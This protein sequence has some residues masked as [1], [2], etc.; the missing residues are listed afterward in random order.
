MQTSDMMARPLFLRMSLRTKVTVLLLAISLGPLLVA[1]VINIDRAVERGMRSE[2]QRFAQ[3]ARF[4]A[5]AF[6]DLFTRVSADVRLMARR[7]PVESF[8]F[9]EVRRELDAGGG[10]RPTLDEW[11]DARILTLLQQDYDSLFVALPDG[12][13]FFTFPY[14]NVTH[15]IDLRASPWFARLAEGGGLASGPLPPLSTDIRP[16]LVALQPLRHRDGNVAGYL[17][18]LI[19]SGRLNDILVRTL[20][21]LGEAGETSSMTLIDDEGRTVAR[22]R[23][24]TMDAELGSSLWKLGTQ[25]TVEVEHP[26]GDHLAA[27]AEVG[28]SG[29]IVQLLTPTDEAYRHVYGLIWLLVVVIVLTFIFVL[30]F[31]DYSAT[32]LLQPIRD[33]ERGAEM[34]GQGALDYRIRLDTHTRDE[35]GHLASAFNTMGDNLLR[36]RRQVEGYS[37]SLETA[38]RELDAMVYGITHDLKKSLRGIEAFASFLGEDYADHIDDEGMEMLASIAA[39]VDRINQ[40]ADDL[41]GLVEHEQR[42]VPTERF[43]MRDLLHEVRER[44]LERH[45]NGRVDLVGEMPAINGDR[46]RLML[47]FDN[48]VDNGLKFNRAARPHIEIRCFDDLLSWRFD[49]ID[50]GIG[51]EPRYH[52]RIFELFARLNHQDEFAGNGTGLNLARRIVEEHRG[53]IEVAPGELGGCRFSVIL[54][55]EANALTAP[56]LRALALPGT[57]NAPDWS[58][59]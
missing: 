41:I 1:G 47:V 29:W 49:I 2:R 13:V 18:A 22:D 54:P 19:S 20:H 57:S 37:R 50:N 30:L 32:L 45:P 26:E 43:E 40:L 42:V 7:F 12:R 55:K 59:G 53:R 9:D 31:A 46:G 28:R 38:Q 27:R 23:A 10:P 44:A 35:L 5:F 3:S 58:E 4:A 25:G 8:H 6:A 51:I 39:N 36:S 48:L 33:L 11:R 14:H 15:P 17:G 21:G 52:D 56:S 24:M 16:G 34:I